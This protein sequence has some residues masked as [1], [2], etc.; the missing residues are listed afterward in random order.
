MKTDKIIE[1]L[2]AGGVLTIDWPEWKIDSA[3]IEA[4]S[5]A[6]FNVRDD[7]MLKEEQ[8]WWAAI[9]IC[10]DSNTPTEY[11][12]DALAQVAGLRIRRS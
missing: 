11:L 2:K 9:R 6:R 4:D 5:P 3:H 12:V 8:A 1:A 10:D 7:S